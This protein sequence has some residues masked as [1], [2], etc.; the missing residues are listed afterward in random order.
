VTV[1]PVDRSGRVDP[2]AVE[3]AIRPET[4][5]ISIMHANNETGTLQQNICDIRPFDG[6]DKI[7][8]AYTDPRGF[9]RDG[10]LTVGLGKGG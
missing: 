9:S 10:L 5:L 3:N 1:L 8:Y 2:K 6:P 7:K 4:V